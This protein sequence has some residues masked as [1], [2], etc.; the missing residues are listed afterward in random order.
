M[1]ALGSPT[2]IDI[3]D[4]ATWSASA[5]EFSAAP[6]PIAGVSGPGVIVPFET[7]NIYIH[8]EYVVN[9]LKIS[10]TAPHSY[11]VSPTAPAV[12]LASDLHGFVFEFGGFKPIDDVLVEIIDGPDAGKNARTL[13]NGWYVIKFV[14]MSVPFTVRASKAGYEALQQQHTG[15][16][17]DPSVSPPSPLNAYLH[18]YLKPSVAPMQNPSGLQ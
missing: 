1:E 13:V 11:A 5:D 7:G 4:V 9:G 3:T 6:T 2:R 8:A 18:F 15:I 14:A 16:V 10:N 17:D 12:A